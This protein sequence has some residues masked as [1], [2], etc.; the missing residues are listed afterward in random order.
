M[1]NTRVDVPGGTP[2]GQGKDLADAQ[3]AVPAV[4]PELVGLNDPQPAQNFGAASDSPQES[5]FEGS[6]I[7]PGAGPEGL[8]TPVPLPDPDEQ[9][10][11]A[12]VPILEAIV[13]QRHNSSARTRQ[14]VRRYRSQL[15][16]K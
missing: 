4:S 10:L 8:S 13:D 16:V 1:S 9:A 14:M 15:P 2:Y 6:R 7:G 3:A 5:L 11:A 12:V